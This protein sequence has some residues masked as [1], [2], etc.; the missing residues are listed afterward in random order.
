MPTIKTADGTE[1]YYK[2]WGA[3]KP[4]FLS[5]GWPLNSDMWEYQMEFLA[6]R[7]LRCVA[8]DR[9]GFG[10]SSQPWNGNNY[11]TMADDIAAVMDALD[12]RDATL[13][14]F[15]MGG[16]D[17]ARYLSRHGAG[18]VS[19]AVLIGAVTPFLLK[20]AD[21]PNGADKSV[22]DGMRAG[23][24]ADRAEFFNGFGRVFMGADNPALKV[25][26]GVLRQ[27]HGMALMA[28]L[29][30]T[31][32]CVIAFSETDF[33]PDMAAFTMPTLIIHG[34]VDTIVPIDLTAREAHK[35]I[36]GSRLEVYAGAPHGLCFTHK[37][38]MNAD[39]LAFI[40]G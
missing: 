23:I 31:L 24:T 36:P 5:H 37:D 11:D 9:R 6:S 12:L 26:E 16:G 15:S 25:S 27:N 39:L 40:N 17:V 34:D 35:A 1:I 20:T 28:S 33:R 38:K 13:V 32:D 29:K 4:V 8:H 2:D 7:G 30:S 18:R 22:F 19:K 14:G 10:R 3:G 21:N